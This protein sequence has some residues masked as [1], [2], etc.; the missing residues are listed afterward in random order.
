MTWRRLPKPK[1]RYYTILN[2]FMTLR[3]LYLRHLAL[4]RPFLMRKRYIVD[5]PNPHT[6]RFNSFRYRAYPWYVKPK[7]S[8]RWGIKAWQIWMVGGTLPGDD[9]AKYHP[10]GYLI[11]E[12]GPEYQKGKGEKQMSETRCKLAKQN[13][14]GCPFKSPHI[15]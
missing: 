14:G 4:P 3:K 10:E 6:G 9:G 7:L 1:Q 8:K 13:R 15:D 11:S 2:T 12:V 5:A